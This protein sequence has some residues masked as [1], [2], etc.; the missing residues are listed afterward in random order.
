MNQVQGR[1][2]YGYIPALRQPMEGDHDLKQALATLALVHA[3]RFTGDNRQVAVASQAILALLSVTKVETTEPNCRY[4]VRSS[5]YCNRVGFA[6]ILALCIYDLPGADEKLI[7]EAERL[8]AFLQKHIRADGSIHY[9]DSPNDKPTQIDPDGINEYPGYAL[10]ALAA[11]H[12]VKPA[13][14]KAEA[15]RKG[16]EYYRALFR[17]NPHPMLAATLTPAFTEFNSQAR[18]PDAIAAVFEINDWLI[19]LQYPSTDPRHPRWVG[20]F[21]GWSNCQPVETAPGYECG[22]YLQSLACAYRLTRQGPDLARE[23]R[24]KPAVLDAVQFVSG[25]QYVEANTRHFENSFRANT[26]IGGFYLSPVDGNLRIDA[27]GAAVLGMLQFL[28]SG[29]E[30]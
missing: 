14:W 22:A 27:T 24:Y 29:A 13:A 18:S 8:S 21:R 17:T 23:A 28:S 10:Q 26:L 20:G 25:L 19:Q 4:P 7:A 9:T 3:A 2:V 5:L 12:R 30:R 15:L 6:A 16:L 1:F 11:G